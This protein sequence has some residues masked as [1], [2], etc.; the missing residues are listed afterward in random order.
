MPIERLRVGC[1]LQCTLPHAPLVPSSRPLLFSAAVKLLKFAMG[2]RGRCTNSPVEETLMKAMY[3]LLCNVLSTLGSLV[4]ALLEGK[5]DLPISGVFGAVKTRSAAILVVGLLVFEPNLNLMILTKENVAAQ[6]FA[7]HI[8]GL[9]M[10]QCI[11]SL[12]L[13]KKN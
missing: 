12:G 9:N 5:T 4:L 6:A 3:P 11:T 10:P 8:E 13:K 1:G 7:E 2:C